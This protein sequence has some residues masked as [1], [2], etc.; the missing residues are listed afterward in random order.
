MNH[1]IT[2]I[3]TTLS[4]GTA[5]TSMLGGTAIYHLQAPD[6][7]ALPYVVFSNAGGGDESLTPSRMTN[8]VW[9]VRAWADDA[10]EA[11]AIMD[12]VDALLHNKTLTVTGWTCFWSMRENIFEL[13][14][15]TGA[16]TLYGAGAY[17]RIRLDS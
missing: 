15:T 10:K 17:Y 7:A 12:A 8:T 1:L 14:D 6:G 4:G 5:L 13:T 16:D 9:N 3:Y 11:W 2:S